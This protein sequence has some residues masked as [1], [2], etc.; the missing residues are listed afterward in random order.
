MRSRREFGL[1]KVVVVVVGPVEMGDPP[2]LDHLDPKH[3]DS[4]PGQGLAAASPSGRAR[5]NHRGPAYLLLSP[6]QPSLLVGEGTYKP[7]SSIRHQQQPRRTT[8]GCDMLKGS[9]CSHREK[10]ER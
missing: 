8:N 6:L 3:W 2:H 1:G 9:P 4:G 5:A 10:A 7:K